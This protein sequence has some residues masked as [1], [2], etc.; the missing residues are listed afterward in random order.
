M[1]N[2]SASP[3]TRDGEVTTSFEP[4]AKPSNMLEMV[5]VNYSI[6]LTDFLI[7]IFVLGGEEYGGT[8]SQTRERAIQNR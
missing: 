5:S 8:S 4:A 6:C 1:L 3:T 2:K 7:V